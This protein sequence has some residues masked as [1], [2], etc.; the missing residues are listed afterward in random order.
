MDLKSMIRDIPDFPKKGIL[1]RDITTLLKDADAYKQ[2]IDDM[3]GSLAGYGVDVV[4]G[5]EAGALL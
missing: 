3:A 5:P 1:F 2:L 4:V